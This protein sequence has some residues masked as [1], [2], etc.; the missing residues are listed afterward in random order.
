MLG[1]RG[2]AGSTGH[3]GPGGGDLSVKG[4]PGS[5]LRLWVTL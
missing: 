1:V 4:Q 3:A 2:L 5:A